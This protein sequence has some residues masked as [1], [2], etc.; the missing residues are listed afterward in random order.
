M[1]IYLFFTDVSSDDD[2]DDYMFADDDLNDLSDQS[3]N[4]SVRAYENYDLTSAKLTYFKCLV[5][6]HKG[7]C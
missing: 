2:D 7:K 3:V 6:S 1:P 5:N 4:R